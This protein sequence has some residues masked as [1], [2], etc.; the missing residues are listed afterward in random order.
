M[1]VGALPLRI[2]GDNSNV[3]NMLNAKGSCHDESLRAL[4]ASAL[5]KLLQVSVLGN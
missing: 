5:N 2:W 4:R 3:V 1:Q